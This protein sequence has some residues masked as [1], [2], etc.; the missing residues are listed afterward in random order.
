VKESSVRSRLREHFVRS[1]YPQP[2]LPFH[3]HPPLLTLPTQLTY[4][5]HLESSNHPSTSHLPHGTP[6]HFR[7]R[8]RPLPRLPPRPHEPTPRSP[9]WPPH[10]S[11]KHLPRDRR[12]FEHR[13]RIPL[14]RPRYRECTARTATTGCG[15]GDTL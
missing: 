7:P 5:S 6:L 11:K 2:P 8:L 9:P 4:I 15:R 14:L 12:R 10:L 1:L 3:T 13:H